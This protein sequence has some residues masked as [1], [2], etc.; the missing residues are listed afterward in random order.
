MPGPTLDRLGGGNVSRKPGK[1]GESVLG[2]VQWVKLK[3]GGAEGW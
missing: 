3:D 1:E 2:S